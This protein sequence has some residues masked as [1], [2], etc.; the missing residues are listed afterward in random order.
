MH[1]HHEV[2]RKHWNQR[3]DAHFKHPD[4]RVKEFLDGQSTLHSLELSEVG[5]V[6]GKT[7]LHLQC[8]FGLDTLS[9]ARLGAKVTGVDISDTSIERANELAAKANLT[10]RFIRSD[11]F[12]VR[13]VLNEQFDIVFA[14]YGTIWWISD[15]DRWAEI[16]A[17]YVK[18]GG[19]F[20]LVEFHPFLCTLDGAKQI[21]EPYFHQPQAERYT[22]EADY[23]DPNLII[24]EEYGWRWTLGD[25]VTALI[26]AGLTIEFLHEFPFCVSKSWRELVKEG[27]WWYYPDLKKDV[28]LMFSVKA[29]PLKAEF[30]PGG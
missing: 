16:V 29:G 30:T 3:T 28:P 13:D 24:E 9:W 22:G 5:D 10:A 7:L 11:I 15:I 17:G 21:I 26:K 20:H 2:N 27:E 12:D 6:Q 19:V 14:S 23:C 25:V 18:K 4:Y 8:H 1:E